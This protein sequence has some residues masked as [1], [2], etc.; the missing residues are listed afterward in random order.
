MAW[1]TRPA[2]WGL[3]SPTED[4]GPPPTSWSSP[5]SLRYLWDGMSDSTDLCFLNAA[6]P[7]S[8]WYP[9]ACANTSRAA[10]EAAECLQP[11]EF[12]LNWEGQV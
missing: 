4:L 2:R 9:V 1:Q 7:G 8:P 11:V 5:H 10:W 3:V 6:R 12:F